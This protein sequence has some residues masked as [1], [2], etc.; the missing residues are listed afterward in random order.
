MQS[1]TIFVLCIKAQNA[2]EALLLAVGVIQTIFIC[3]FLFGKGG[4]Q[5][6]IDQVFPG[7]KTSSKSPRQ[8]RDAFAIATAVF[9]TFD[10]T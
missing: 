2:W 6:A 10:E 8:N 7:T 1:I 3:T 9:E 5:K 4:V